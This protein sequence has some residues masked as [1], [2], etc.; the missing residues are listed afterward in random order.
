MSAAKEK[1]RKASPMRVRFKTFESQFATRQ[2]ILQMAAEFATQLGPERLINI[3]HT[4]DRD[5]EVVTI[6]YWEDSHEGKPAG[7]A[8]GPAHG[9]GLATAGTET[10]TD[11][12]IT[13]SSAPAPHRLAEPEKTRAAP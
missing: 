11:M 4:E 7:M 1:H 9:E 2:K 12:G 8:G 10:V 5:D 13:P 3:T 6:W